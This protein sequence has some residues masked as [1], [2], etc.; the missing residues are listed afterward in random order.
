MPLRKLCP[1]PRSL[2]LGSPLPGL[3]VIL[4]DPF[5]DLSFMR[6]RRGRG[7]PD[8]SALSAT[9]IAGLRSIPAGFGPG[10]GRRPMGVSRFQCPPRHPPPL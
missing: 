10:T 8:S 9:G 7:S 5:A 1:P 2:L 4:E 6:V 3:I